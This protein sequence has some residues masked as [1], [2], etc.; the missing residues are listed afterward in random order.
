MALLP[1]A[2]ALLRPPVPA[3]LLVAALGVIVAVILFAATGVVHQAERLA[4]RLGDPYGSLV[5]TLSVVVIEVILICAVMLGPGEHAGI[6]RDSVMAVSMIILNLVIGLCLLVGGVRHGALAHHRTG[7]SAYLAMLAVLGALAFALPPVLGTGGAYRPGQAVVVALLALGS[8]AFFL[9]R[10][11]GAQAHDF[12]EVDPRV[13]PGTEPHPAGAVRSPSSELSAVPDRWPGA[14][15]RYD[16]R[17]GASEESPRSRGGAARAEHRPE[18]LIRLLVLVVTVLPVVLL[19]HE[20]AAL[21]DDGLGRAGA[22]PALAGVLIAA[23]VFL[24]ESITSVRAALAGE[25]Q[26]VSNLCH[27]ALVSTLGLTIPAVL[28]I[29]L[30]TD[31]RV[32]LAESPVTLV[33]L[34]LSLALSAITFTAP[35]VTA[36]H[37]AAHLVVFA[38]YALSVFS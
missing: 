32:V 22:P 31:Q 11:T 4:A 18:I 1:F 5:L 2:A 6:A 26:R 3:P 10:Q 28:V 19:S 34:G 37:G 29:G 38:A 7:A 17:P 13:R 15:P 36:V 16:A 20:M 23:V 27:G 21:L 33:L 14:L 12:T 25:I 8:Y 24:P 9:S 35:R 30:L